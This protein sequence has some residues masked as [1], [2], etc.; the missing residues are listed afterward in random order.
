[1]RSQED[2]FEEKRKTEDGF[3]LFPKKV[4]HMKKSTKIVKIIVFF[5]AQEKPSF[6]LKNISSA[7]KGHNLA[8]TPSLVCQ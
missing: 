1:M 4:M 8:P 6:M 2:D 3:V 7:C 5:P